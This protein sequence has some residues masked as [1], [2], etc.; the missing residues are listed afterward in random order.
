MMSAHRLRLR[1]CLFSSSASSAPAS[2]SFPLSRIG[3]TAFSPRTAIAASGAC[4][5]PSR[6]LFSFLKKKE[7][8]QPTAAATSQ[9]QPEQQLNEVQQ[10]ELNLNAI[11]QRIFPSSSECRNEKRVGSCSHLVLT[12]RYGKTVPLSQQFPALFFHQY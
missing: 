8:D 12:E 7:K 1:P 6:S 2:C 4:C 5:L 3:S 10:S 11:F 9:Q